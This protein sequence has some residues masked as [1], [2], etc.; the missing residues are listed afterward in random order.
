MVLLHS[1]FSSLGGEEGLSEIKVTEAA[2]F[3]KV[4]VLGQ[5]VLEE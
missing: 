1:C 3:D 5:K 4:R 2:R